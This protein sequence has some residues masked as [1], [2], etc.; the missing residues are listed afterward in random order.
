MRILSKNEPVKKGHEDVIHH[1]LERCRHIRQPEWHVK[2]LKEALMRLER[3]LLN[4]RQ[5][6]ADLVVTRRA[7]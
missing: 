2:E 4:V 6:H 3:R 7:W 1:C 5:V